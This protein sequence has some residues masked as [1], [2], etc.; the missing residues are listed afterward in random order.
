MLF[1]QKQRNLKIGI[2]LITF[3]FFVFILKTGAVFPLH[4]YYIIPFV[5]VM[6]IVAAL[7]LDIIPVKLQ[8]LFLGAIAFESIANQFYDFRIPENEKYKANLESI[9]D[10][11][12]PKGKLIVING[13]QSPQEIYFAHRKGWTVSNEV[14]NRKD[15]D[16]L[17]IFGA[18][19]LVL[20]KK[21]QPPTIDYYPELYADTHYAIYEIKN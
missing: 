11:Y 10:A 5:P 2:G 8:Y 21:D 18:N 12:I 4:N 6:C 20:N 9:V 14:I 19:Y 16:S 3:I 13:T 1:R 17:G 7:G 15:L